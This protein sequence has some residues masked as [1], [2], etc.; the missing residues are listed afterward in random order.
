VALH[1]FGRDEDI[2]DMSAEDCDTLIKVVSHFVGE[3]SILSG[4]LA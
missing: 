2:K 4:W 3:L 1:G